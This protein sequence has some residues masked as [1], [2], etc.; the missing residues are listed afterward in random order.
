VVQHL[1]HKEKVHFFAIAQPYIRMTLQHLV[2]PS[3]AAPQGT[4]SH[5]GWRTSAYKI[6]LPRQTFLQF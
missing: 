2:K 1:T 4:D 3:R 6:A 5:K